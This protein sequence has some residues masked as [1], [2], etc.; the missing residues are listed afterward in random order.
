MGQYNLGLAYH[1]GRGVAQD[2]WQ[3]VKWYRLAAKQGDG[4]AQ[5][6]LGVMY[7]YGQGAPQDYLRAYMW[8]NL[9]ASNLHG[10]KAR[11]AANNRD[12]IAKNITP[13]QVR[14]AQEMTRQ[15]VQSDYK[16]C[17]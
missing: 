6:N 11:Q 9:A 13:V 2:Y 4:D 10:D 1:E 12:T 15:C 3:A 16:E 5:N 14:R 8:L 17:D 7:K